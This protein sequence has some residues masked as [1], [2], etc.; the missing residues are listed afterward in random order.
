[1]NRANRRA[2]RN[3]PQAQPKVPHHQEEVK[4]E[5]P[6]PELE[7]SDDED[8]GTKMA[9]RMQQKGDKVAKP[10]GMPRQDRSTAPL[11]P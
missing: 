10:I 9:L 4:A 3:S 6:K 2:F 7:W 11:L 5:P 8:D 1:M